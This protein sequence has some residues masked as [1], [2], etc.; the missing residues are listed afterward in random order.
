MWQLSTRRRSPT[1]PHIDASS[2]ACRLLAPAGR[3]LDRHPRRGRGPA[4]HAHGPGLPHG[5]ARR[6]GARLHRP[7]AARRRDA[8]DLH[9]RD[10]ERERRARADRAERGAG[11]RLAAARRLRPP[12]L[13][14]AALA[15]HQHHRLHPAPRRRDRR[16]AQPAPARICR[17]HHALVGARCSRSST[18]SS[19]SP[20]STPARWSSRREDVDIRQTIEAAA[21][22]IEDRLAEVVARARDRCAATT[23]ARFEADGKRVRQILFNLLSNAVGFSAAGPDRHA[24]RPARAASDVV[25]EVQDQGRGIPPEVASA[26][27]RALREPHARH[28][29]SRR[30]PRPVDRALLRRAAWRPGRADLGSRVA[31]RRSPASS[32]AGRRAATPSPPL[33]A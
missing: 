33:A 30:R 24:S 20:R 14:R 32:P 17:P 5:A 12:R 9:R 18:T 13:L 29:P 16:A 8:P 21:R 26:R 10:R 22:G 1:S 7:A 28:P 11:A 3:A 25:F 2:G 31:A 4:R 27:L 15:A 6:L 19:T 23:S